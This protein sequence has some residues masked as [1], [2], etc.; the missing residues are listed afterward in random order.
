MNKAESIK[1]HVP[2]QNLCMACGLCCD[3]TL[4]KTARVDP[5]ERLIELQASGV[6]IHIENERRRLLL[7]CA[8]YENNICKAYY[9]ERA[10]VCTEYQCKLLKQCL[11]GKITWDEAEEVVRTT[12]LH[13]KELEANLRKVYRFNSGKSLTDIFQRFIGSHGGEADAIVFRKKHA[14]LLLDYLAFNARLDLY[15]R[16]KKKQE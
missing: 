10:K 8:A 1:E 4:F 6:Q 3:G 11:S 15:F 12:Q 2:E 16:K 13:K 14:Q 7:P 5:D 9:N